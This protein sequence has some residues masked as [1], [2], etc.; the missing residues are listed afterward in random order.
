MLQN[1]FSGSLDLNFVYS[2]ILEAVDKFQT[3][4]K[5]DKNI[6]IFDIDDT[7]ICSHTKKTIP[8]VIDFYKYLDHF[9]VDKVL[10]TARTAHPEVI[11]YTLNQ[12]KE[13]EITGFRKIF[14]RPPHQNDI[15]RFKT[16]SRKTLVEEGYIP[17]MSIGDM[18]WDTGEFGGHPIVLR[19]HF[20]F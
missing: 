20:T 13:L 19:S 5:N 7:L 8:H 2:K 1:S 11:Q 14:F 6:I 3:S 10:I 9:K 4:I 12:L 15:A 16:M 17:L 18:H